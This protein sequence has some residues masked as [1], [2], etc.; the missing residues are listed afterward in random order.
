MKKC[1][2][3]GAVLKG[4]PNQKY[5]N[6]ICRSMNWKSKKRLEKIGEETRQMIEKA[7]IVV[8]SDVVDLWRK[9]FGR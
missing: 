4:R 6:D 7:N 3:C 8:G 9:I 1:N 2:Y 5:C